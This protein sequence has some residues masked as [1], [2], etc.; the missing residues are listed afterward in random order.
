ME[1]YEFNTLDISEK[2]TFTFNNSDLLHA[3][4]EGEKRYLL[5][6]TLHFYVEVE[7]DNTENRIMGIKAFKSIRPLQRFL[8]HIHLPD[9]V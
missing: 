4:N 3:I 6:S 8:N 5:Y 1:L 2:A 9:L 7:Y